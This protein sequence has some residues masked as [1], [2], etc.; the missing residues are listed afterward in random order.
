MTLLETMEPRVLL[1]ATAAQVSA[2]VGAYHKYEAAITVD[3]KK[4]KTEST[5][6]FKTIAA[7]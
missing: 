1:S 5:A 6:G 7:D 3:I 4:L 2:A